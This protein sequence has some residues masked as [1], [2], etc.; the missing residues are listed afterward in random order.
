MAEYI[1]REAVE[2][3]VLRYSNGDVSKQELFLL[4]DLMGDITAIQ[5]ADVQ[6]VKSGKW[7]WK[8]RYRNSYQIVKGIDECGKEG[9]LQIHE[10]YK[11]QVN[12]CSECGKQGHEVFLN[13]CPNC[14]A[15]MDGDNNA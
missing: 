12:Y 13:Y 2:K 7:V 6:P 8:E 10:E 11:E 5:S 1:E 3:A 14:G 15:R 4:T 9:N